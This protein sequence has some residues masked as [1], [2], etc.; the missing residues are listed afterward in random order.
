MNPIPTSRFALVFLLFFSTQLAAQSFPGMDEAI[1]RGD[2]GPLKAVLISQ[3]GETVFE[4]YYRGTGADD[5]HQVQSVTK[6]VGSAL[7]GIAH[8]QGKLSLANTLEYY[9]SDLYPMHQ[10]PYSDKAAITVEQVLQQ[11]HGVAWNEDQADYRDSANPVLQMILSPDWYDFF[12]S[13]P[14]ADAPGSR[15]DYSSG[16]STLMSRIIRVAT[17]MGPDQFARQALF[18]PLGIG[19]VHWELYSE[20]GM[21]HGQTDW[22]N[23]DGDPSLGFSLWL[24]AGDLLKIGELYLNGGMHQ[25]RR[26]LDASWIR[27]SWTRYSHSGNSDYFS[28]AGWGHGY[29]WWIALIEDLQGRPWNV[30][31]ASGW[32]AQVIFVVPELGLVMVTTADGYDYNGPNVDALLVGHVLSGLNPRLDERFNGA[33]FDPDADGQGITLEID[34]E[35]GVVAG[36]WY[37]YD[38]SGSQRWFTLQGTADGDS[39][40]V[41]IYETSGGRFLLGQPPYVIEAWGS[42]Q[43]LTVGCDHIEFSFQ[44]EETSASIPLRRLTGLCH[45]AP[46]DS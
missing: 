9:F 14:M 16:A 27:A 41:T 15:F 43:L 29:Q 46:G 3:H 11:R 26:I 33:W 36:F 20:E 8:R 31:F 42:G 21:G 37:T 13:R 40:S 45:D 4:S 44:A 10:A 28:L 7:L 38:D 18:D 19:P 6:S 30:Y 39:A 24:R 25:G 5:L 35:S 12:L 32:G 2:Y 34:R 23:P 22:P 1:G 17:G